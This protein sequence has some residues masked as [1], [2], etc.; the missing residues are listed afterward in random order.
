MPKFITFF[1]YTAEAAKAMIERPS[2]RSAAGKAL[3]ESLGGTQ[4]AFYWMQGKHDG[5]LISNMPDGVSAAALSAAVGAA[6]AVERIET[7]QIF[8][9]DEQAAIVQQA[10]TAR[11]AYTPP[12]A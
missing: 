6:G 4:E 5:F 11:K 9:R 2:D 7:H 8:D 3:A 12:T 10:D 1:S